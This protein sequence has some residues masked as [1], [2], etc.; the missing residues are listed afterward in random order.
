MSRLPAYVLVCLLHLRSELNGL[1]LPGAQER[2]REYLLGPLHHHYLETHEPT[3][4]RPSFVSLSVPRRL[5]NS[6]SIYFDRMR[7][8]AHGHFFHLCLHKQ[9]TY[10]PHSLRIESILIACNIRH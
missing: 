9:Y 5:L 6:F 8:M 2:T 4:I 10:T 3:L 7:T 1:Q